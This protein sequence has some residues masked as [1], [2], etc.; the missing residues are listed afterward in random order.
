MLHNY[1]NAITLVVPIAPSGF[2]ITEVYFTPMNVIV[3][4]EWD[5]PQGMGPEFVV[6]YYRIT[7]LSASLSHPIMNSV[8]STIWNV[9]LN[10]NTI[11][12]A[13]ISAINCAGESEISPLIDPFQYGGL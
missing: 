10:Y 2:N 7:I 4:F 13:N 8:D 12:R 11:Y 6:D 5:L 9:T 1:Y 3:T